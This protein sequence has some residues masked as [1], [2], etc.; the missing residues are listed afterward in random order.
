MTS[1]IL[2]T[3]NQ[4]L[5]GIEESWTSCD[6]MLFIK[7]YSNHNHH[8]PSHSPGEP[9]SASAMVPGC[10]PG[11]RFIKGLVSFFSHWFGWFPKVSL[12]FL[13]WFPKV[14]L[15]MVIFH[16]FSMVMLTISR[17]DQRYPELNTENV[18]LQLCAPASWIPNA[19]AQ[20]Y[21]LKSSTVIKSFGFNLGS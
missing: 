15:H 19:V 13:W 12:H 14:S 4:S 16:T 9:I 20:V 5:T 8:Q 10:S 11:S 3:G 1:S 2:L 7:H 6:Y 18:F 21:R 17:V